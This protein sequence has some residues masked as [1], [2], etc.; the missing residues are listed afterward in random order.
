M[1]QKSNPDVEAMKI[2]R[3]VIII[4]IITAFI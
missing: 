4:I 2:G 3:R 1:S